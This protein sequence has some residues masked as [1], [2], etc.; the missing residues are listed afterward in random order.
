MTACPAGLNTSV[1]DHTMLRTRQPLI[2]F[3]KS[4]PCLLPSLV[5][6]LLEE[7]GVRAHPQ[8]RWSVQRAIDHQRLERFAVAGHTDD[9][10]HPALV[11]AITARVPQ[12]GTSCVPCQVELRSRPI[13]AGST[14][15][16][17]DNGARIQGRPSFGYFPWPRKESDQLPGC[18]R[19][20]VSARDAR[21]LPQLWSPLAG[22]DSHGI[23][24]FTTFTIFTIFTAPIKTFPPPPPSPP[25]ARSNRL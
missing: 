25:P 6:H 23:H 24:A 15:A 4:E 9:L 10:V 17:R 13:E 21:P 14:G 20:G 22:H 3:D 7:H 8:T 12:Q 18:P 16:P 2:F 19:P 1:P 5:L 11:M